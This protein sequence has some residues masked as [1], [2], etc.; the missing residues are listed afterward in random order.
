MVFTVN[1]GFADLQK[2][3]ADNKVEKYVLY[4]GDTVLVNEVNTVSFLC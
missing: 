1:I 3:G 4:I 2:K